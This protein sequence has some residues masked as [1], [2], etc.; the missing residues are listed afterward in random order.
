M[1]DYA[2]ET[3]Y[4]IVKL[5]NVNETYNGVLREGYAISPFT[6]HRT[7]AKE[8]GNGVVRMA[9]L[10]E[11]RE[12]TAYQ[13]IAISPKTFKDAIATTTYNGNVRLAGMDITKAKNDDVLTTEHY[14]KLEDI[15]KTF[16]DAIAKNAM[17][18]GL[19]GMFPIDN[20]PEGWLRADGTKHLKST[21]NALALY[22]GSEYSVD[23]NYF[24]TPDYSG[25]FLR[26][27]D[28]IGKVDPNGK[29]RKVGS[30]QGDAIRNIVGETEGSG[31]FDHATKRTGA[32]KK[33]G[34][35]TTSE[36]WN[37]N[38]V[39]SSVKFDASLV[40]PTAEENRPINK[41]VVV[42]IRAYDSVKNPTNININDLLKSYNDLSKRVSALEKKKINNNFNNRESGFFI[43][44]NTGFTIQWG[45]ANRTGG[46][47]QVKFGMEFSKKCLNV[48]VTQYTGD[49]DT[50]R[51]ISVIDFTKSGFRLQAK[52]NEHRIMWIAIGE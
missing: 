36:A 32:F 30:I 26:G 1:A 8:D 50:T 29:T 47:T 3:V 46:T 35:Y 28:P 2:T 23:K 10:N 18:I 31:D 37:G 40:V 4:G 9:T 34:S 13:G 51:N 24:V 33:V 20:I 16:D 7:I 43:D 25:Y 11:L 5:A 39:R 41:T 48:S 14:K 27:H 45:V 19:L 15:I 17:P 52:S 21:F 22:L 42:C 44:E 38:T 12:G 49:T 6:F